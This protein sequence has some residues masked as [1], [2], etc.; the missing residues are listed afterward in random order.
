MQNIITL[1]RRELA[2]YFLSP[3][4]YVILFLFLLFTGSGFQAY[5]TLFQQLGGLEGIDVTGVLAGLLGG[6]F[7]WYLLPLLI[8]VL[9][10]RSLAGEKSSGRIEMLFTAPVKDGE[11]V[12]AKF[13]GAFLFYVILWSTTLVYIGYTMVI[14]GEPD[15]GV[16]ASSYLGLLLVG[17]MMIAINLLFSALTSN[18]VVALIVSL[19]FNLAL[20][21]FPLILQF[22]TSHPAL[23]RIAAHLDLPT[24]FERDFSS[25]IV[26]TRHLVYYG[27]TMLLGLFLTLRAVE[28][29]KWR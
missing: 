20:V 7:L 16:L 11:V 23:R 27:S 25:G 21:L 17:A 3:L 22:K 4:A 15:W 10:F 8:P 13:L 6:G 19:F 5:L 28:V 26:D 2:G 9:T 1:T 18:V 29:R 14:G 24:H 12:L